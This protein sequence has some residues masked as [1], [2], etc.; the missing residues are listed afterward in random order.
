MARAVIEMCGCHRGRRSSVRDTPP[1]LCV[2]RGDFGRLGHGDCADVFIPRRIACLAE[3]TVKTITC[4]DTHTLAVLHDG[5]LFSFGRNQ[6]GQ[7]GNGT[8]DDCLEARM[9]SN[10]AAETVTGAA[11]GAEHSVCVTASGKVF[12]WGWGRYGNLGVSS[13]VDEC[14]PCSLPRPLV[15]CG[16]FVG[17]FVRHVRLSRAV[18]SGG[19]V[20]RAYVA[21]VTRRRRAGCRPC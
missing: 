12:S 21:S 17:A 7:L 13:Y 9:V 5:R 20:P 1:Q 3:N 14:A 15:L 2:C 10:L 18:Q 6:N 8:N 4:G 16:V 19:G 11:C